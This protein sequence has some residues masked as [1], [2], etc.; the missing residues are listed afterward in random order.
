M[1]NSP[2]CP[3]EDKVRTVMELDVPR[4]KKEVRAFLGLAGYCRKFILDLSYTA[5][6]VSYQTCKTAPNTVAWTQKQQ[7]LFDKLKQ[8]L[9]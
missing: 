4:W 5:A 6:P 9:T 1:R 8:E 7:E 3:E 2:V